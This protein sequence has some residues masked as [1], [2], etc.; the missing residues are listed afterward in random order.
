MQE[1]NKA[2]QYLHVLCQVVARFTANLL[3][4][5]KD[6]SHTNLSLDPI[7]KRILSRWIKVADRQLCLALNLEKYNF[8]L[9]RSDLST[10]SSITIVNSTIHDLEKALL[11]ELVDMGFDGKEF[12]IKL[13]YELP[14]YPFADQEFQSL[15]LNEISTWLEFRTLANEFCFY[16]L[17]FVNAGGEVR[18]WPH[19]FDTGVYHEIN[20]AIGFGFGL[21]MKDTLVEAPYFYLSGYAL[22]GKL[23]YDSLP[24]LSHGEWKTG[25]WKGALLSLDIIKDLDHSD[26]A[27]ILA[28][29]IRSVYDQY[30]NILR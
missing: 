30:W 26:R 10:I 1:Y 20:N 14:E 17:Q 22:E 16:F 3:P 8:E 18:I 13:K 19:H 25:D 27:K 7:S 28:E 4:E 21:A 6:Y 5:N 29:F 24:L 12:S 15:S 2:D 23:N 9:L 11:N